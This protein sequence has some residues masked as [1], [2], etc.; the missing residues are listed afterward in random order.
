MD[1]L[2][3]FMK[4]QMSIGGISKNVSDEVEALWNE[5]KLPQLENDCSIISADF[6]NL[7]SLVIR[8]IASFDKAEPFK[9]EGGSYDYVSVKSDLTTRILWTD[10]SN[11][12]PYNRQGGLYCDGATF[13]HLGSPVIENDNYR[14][15]IANAEYNSNISFAVWGYRFNDF[16][17]SISFGICLKTDKVEEFVSKLRQI[18]GKPA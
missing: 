4:E 10:Y 13:E 12:E 3:N 16:Y 1:F 18:I 9:Y 14:E 2:V 17:N 6:G 11:T 7:G 8:R 15:F 5:Y